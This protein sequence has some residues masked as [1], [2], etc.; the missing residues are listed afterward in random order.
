[1]LVVRVVAGDRAS[2]ATVSVS[3][4][5]A[6]EWAAN[7]V[8]NVDPRSLEEALTR[9]G[10]EYPHM[11]HVTLVPEDDPRASSWPRW[12]VGVAEPPSDILIFPGRTARYP[13]DSLESVVRHEVAHLALTERA[14]GRPLPRWFH[15]G[16]AVSIEAGFGVGDEARLFTSM[17]SRPGIGDLDRLFDSGSEA[18]SAR[19]YLLAT[20]LVADVRRR[21]GRDI[22]GAIADGAGRD[23]GFD[24][25]FATATGETVGEATTVA[26]AGYLRWTRWILALDRLVSTWTLVLLLAIAAFVVRR[27]RRARHRQRWDD[28]APDEA[29]DEVDDTAC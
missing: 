26:W 1:L 10:L 24:Q 19:A 8:R 29:A 27:R 7:R 11:V 17:A 2:A 5:P 28:E 16:V 13:Y 12:V 14:R 4:P 21:H 9:A 3:A 18:E 15:E 23:L 25:A 22:V 20:A 6:L